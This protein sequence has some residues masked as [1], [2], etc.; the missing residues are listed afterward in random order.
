MNQLLK[1]IEE[2]LSCFN[3]I[4]LQQMENVRLMNRVNT[5]FIA[6][7]ELQPLVLEDLSQHYRVLEIENCRAFPYKTEYF[8]TKTFHM[9]VAHQNGKL[10]RYKIRK[11]EYL[12][13]GHQYLEIKLKTN[14]GRT[15]K[16]RIQRLV[17]DNS[18]SLQENEFLQQNSPYNT[19]DLEFK[20][21]N[22]FKR[23][24][25]VG[26]EE[27]LTIDFNLEF[28]DEKNNI[29]AFPEIFI[30]EVKQKKFNPNTIIKKVLK[31]RNIRPQSFSKYCIGAASFNEKIKANMLKPKF[32]LIKKIQKEI[33]S[34]TF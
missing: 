34:Y 23:I 10:N 7:Y 22:Q 5:K 8:D 27:R 17:K 32:E 14:K 3:P 9:Y 11:R 26:K 12:K 20:L 19:K 31:K 2:K 25:L 15:L 33:D 4:S 13:I 30:A 28:G 29:L 18:F 6:P 16:K 21:F 1:I 24:T